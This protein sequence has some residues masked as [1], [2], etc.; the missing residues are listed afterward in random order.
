[1]VFWHPRGLELLR[2]LE[3][4][5]RRELARHGYREVRTPELLE[6]EIWRRSGH[7]LH[8]V[9]GM[10]ALD[11][12]AE[13]GLALRPVNCPGHVQIYADEVRSYRD[14]PLRLAEFGVVHRREPSG[15]LQGLFRLREFTQDDGH[16]FCRPD[17]VAAELESFCG[18]LRDFYRRFGFDDLIVGWSTRPASRLGD[19]ASWDRAEAALREAASAVGFSILE[20][21]GEGAFYGPKLEF[22]LRDRLGRV[23]QC[24]TIQVDFA[25]PERFGLAYVDR[26]GARRRPV[27]LHRALYGSLERFLG[28]LLEHHAGKLPAWLAPEQ[29]HVLAVSER[30]A[31]PARELAERLRRRG[32]RVVLT[33]PADR[34]SARV[35]AARRA[36]V[37][38]VLVVGPR[39]ASSGAVS[40]SAAGVTRVEAAE[41]AVQ[42]VAAAAD[43]RSAA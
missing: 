24:G 27:M 5:A 43:E 39:E 12:S 37:P 42:R 31:E 15:A 35:H 22:K 20:Q 25:M 6:N 40:V 7:A 14:L 9:E 36:G 8:F 33:D 38:F 23:W 19:D 16:V 30:E 29:A 11:E 4:A 1:M 10:F 3:R 21:P 2:G 41:Q 17:Q 32:V 18:C 13:H 26:D 28:V 34:L